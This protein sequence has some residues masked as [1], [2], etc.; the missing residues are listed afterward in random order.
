MDKNIVPI[1][2]KGVKTRKEAFGGLVFTNR[3][4]I[5]SLNHDSIL[6]W[7]AIDGVRSLA[8]ICTFLQTMC[9]DRDIDIGIIEE[10][11]KVCKKLD[12]IE[13]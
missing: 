12:L 13:Y 6:I 10:F 7:D 2:K 1:F 3:T 5:L 8:E 9:P 11:F 4:P